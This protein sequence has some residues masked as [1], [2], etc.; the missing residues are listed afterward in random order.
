MPRLIEY[1]PHCGSMKELTVS[2]GMI[3]H[4]T[5]DGKEDVLIYQYHC[6]KCNSYLRSTTLDYEDVTSH[7]ESE[8]AI[9]SIP[10]YV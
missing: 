1:C 6:A 7:Y 10:E 4:S 9:I 2:L 5:P 3:S 8:R